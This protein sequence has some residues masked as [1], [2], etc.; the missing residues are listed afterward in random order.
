M[1]KVQY[2]AQQRRGFNLAAFPA[3]VAT[4]GDFFGFN[5]AL[6]GY[7][8]W[9]DLKGVSKNCWRNILRKSMKT[10]GVCTA[11]HMEVEPQIACAILGDQA[12]AQLCPVFS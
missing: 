12:I 2:I 1:L 8:W 10:F 3:Q 11:S 6:V 7:G 9:S 5:F 4:G